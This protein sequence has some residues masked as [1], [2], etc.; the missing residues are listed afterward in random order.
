MYTATIGAVLTRRIVRRLLAGKDPGQEIISDRETS[1][2]YPMPGEMD[3]E[4]YFKQRRF[5]RIRDVLGLIFM[6]R[7]P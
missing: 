2:Y 1:Q 3:F 4:A 6:R 7:K 5:F